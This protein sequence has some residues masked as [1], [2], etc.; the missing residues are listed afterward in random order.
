VPVELLLHIGLSIRSFREGGQWNLE[1]LTA[2]CTYPDD[3][4]GTEPFNYQQIPLWH[5]RLVSHSASPIASLVRRALQQSRT[6]RNP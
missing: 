5:G 6:E 2:K 1:L 3:W 4:G